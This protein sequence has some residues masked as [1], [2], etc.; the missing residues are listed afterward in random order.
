MR[1]LT[2][3]LCASLIAEA[4]E[5]PKERDAVKN[6][7]ARGAERY[8]ARKYDEAVHEFSRAI[9]LDPKRVDAYVQRGHCHYQKRAYKTAIVNYKAALELQANHSSALFTAGLA[10]QYL[11]EHENALKMFDEAVKH[12][13]IWPEAYL[14]RGNSRRELLDY[15]G[16]V[17]DYGEAIALKQLREAYRARALVN[18]DLGNYEAAVNDYTT[19]IELHSGPH[20]ALRLRARA[21]F[22]LHKRAK[23]DEDFTNSLFLKDDDPATWTMRARVRKLAG[24]YPGAL[25]D[26][27][28]AI[29]LNRKSPHPYFIRGLIHY[30]FKKY[31]KALLDLK[32][33]IRRSGAVE[34]DYMWLYHCLIRMRLRQKERGQT[35]LKDYV[36]LKKEQ[37]TAWFATVVKFLTGEIN[38]DDFLSAAK[39]E[40]PK[41]TAERRCEAFFYA[42]TLRMA[43]G[44]REGARD[45]FRKSVATQMRSFIEYESSS[46][47][48]QRGG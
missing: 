46:I 25:A 43:A 39:D 45:F 37:P 40:T 42:G 24:D 9:E 38:E 41:T 28:K 34:P 31:R 20:V 19:L 3:L 22:F 35:E 33:A 21:Y 4:Q 11:K 6:R 12:Y 13:P 15:A 8:K 17:E 32:K 23:C 48:I 2:V 47:E 10:Y 27:S 18:E 36:A 7:M 14:R 1:I 5:E 26:C 30:D 29:E 16:A 44:N